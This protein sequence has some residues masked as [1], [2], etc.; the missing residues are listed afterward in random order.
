MIAEATQKAKLYYE[1]HITCDSGN[2]FDEFTTIAKYNGWRSSRF[3][4]DNVDFYNGKWFLSYRETD[5]KTMKSSI[6]LII[7]E[8]KQAGYSVIR[9]K[10][11]D[12]LF[13]S[14]Y[15]DVL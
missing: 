14:K 6:K 9:W 8:L 1:A 11:E 15:G 10:I 3:D 7:N 4:E 12:T 2:D 13:D 5:L